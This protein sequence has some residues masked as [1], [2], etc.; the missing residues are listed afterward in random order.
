MEKALIIPESKARGLYQGSSGT[1]KQAFE[2]TFGKPFL[3]PDVTDRVRSF[4]DALVETGRPE[5]PA[6][7]DVPEDLREYFR[8][9]YRCLVICEALND[10]KRMDIYDKDKPRHYPWFYPEGSPARFRFGDASCADTGANAGSGSRL[11]LMDAKRAEYAG[12]Q[13]SDEFK[14]LLS[15]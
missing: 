9:S 3:S 7:A 5:V 10:G 2:D 6:F 8:A 11:S 1:L 14:S 12:R 15:V 4:E 13:F